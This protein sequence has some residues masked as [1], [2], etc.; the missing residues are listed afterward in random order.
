MFRV[1][2]RFKAEINKID[3]IGKNITDATVKKRMLHEFFFF[4][5]AILTLIIQSGVVVMEIHKIILGVSTIGVLYALKE[6][7]GRIIGPIA[8]FN[9]IFIDYQIDKVTLRKFN[10]FLDLPDDSNTENRN[11]LKISNGSISIENVS[12]AYEENPVLSDFSFLIEGESTL[13]IVGSSG[14]GKSTIAKLILSL[15]KPQKGEILI[16]SQNLANCNLDSIYKHLSYISQDAPVFDGTI[17]E[18][19]D[20]DNGFDDSVLLDALEK[21]QLRNTIE[22]LP[23]GLHTEIGE[24]GICLSGGEK[25]RL[26]IARLFL[27]KPKII[28]LDEPTAAMDSITEH[29]ITCQMFSLFKDST[30]VVIAHRL[31]TIKQADRIIVMDNGKI[32]QEGAFENLVNNPGKFKELW[33][34]QTENKLKAE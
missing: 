28:I 17:R 23:F 22:R 13:A 6:F 31:Q 9:V 34:K 27:Q 29:F 7:T 30:M 1:N 24:K 14:S 32:C 20:F 3:R 15:L 21:T 4:F 26:A 19:L 5:V 33:E 16:D 8:I 11:R 25:Q 18:N 2:L 12:F 10:D